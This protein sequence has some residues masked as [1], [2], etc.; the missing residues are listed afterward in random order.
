MHGWRRPRQ[1]PYGGIN[2]VTSK[3]PKPGQRALLVRT[4]EAGKSDH[5]C[6]QDG[7][8]FPGAPMQ[9]LPRRAISTKIR[10]EP[11]N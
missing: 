3:C 7:S 9:P 2:Q 8:G 6:N 11:H 1:S 10:Q 4:D 5:I